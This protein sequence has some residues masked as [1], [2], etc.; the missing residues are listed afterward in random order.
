VTRIIAGKAGSLR[1]DV[2]QGP[3]RPTSERVREAI[4]SAI[5]HLV[6][7][8]GAQVLDLYAGSG[9]LGL[10]AASR[11]ATRV[12]LVDSSKTVE[13]AL[14]ANIARIQQSLGDSHTFQ[15]V[16]SPALA[17]CQKIP[18]GESF[19]LVLL[20]PPYDTSP[21]SIVE[22]LLALQPALTSDSLVV[23]E[24]AKKSPEPEWPQSFDVIKH[25]TYGDTAVFYLVTRR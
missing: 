15:V 25:K 18:S 11:G 22:C 9:A 6:D 24:R 2:P 12:V 17:Y 10:E 14:T 21:E 3:T 4:F 19:D 13:R 7:L 16:T 20:D 5:D 23:V 1:L 8:G